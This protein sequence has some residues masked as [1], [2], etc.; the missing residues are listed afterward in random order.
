MILV[1]SESGDILEVPKVQHKGCK[2]HIYF[3]FNNIIW[4]SDCRVGFVSSTHF[5]E[6]I[7]LRA[8]TKVPEKP[9]GAQSKLRLNHVTLKVHIVPV[10]QLKKMQPYGLQCTTVY[11]LD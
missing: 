1:S 6:K 5:R 11:I 4:K 9:P 7:H 2:P 10:W 8:Q 3:P